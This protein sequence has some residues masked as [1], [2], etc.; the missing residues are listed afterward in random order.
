[1]LHIYSKKKTDYLIPERN[2]QGVFTIKSGV[3]KKSLEEFKERFYRTARV[4]MP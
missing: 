4:Y 1:V 2:T 3:E